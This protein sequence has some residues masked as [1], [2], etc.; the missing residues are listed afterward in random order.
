[1]DVKRSLLEDIKLNSFNDTDSP[2]D[3]GEVTAKR[4]TGMATIREKE[5]NTPKIIWAEGIRK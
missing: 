3:G 4:S 2:K 5:T 1:M